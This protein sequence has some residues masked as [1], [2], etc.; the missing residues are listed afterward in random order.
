MKEKL[1]F[2]PHS[3]INLLT[4]RETIDRAEERTSEIIK[5]RDNS[6]FLLIKAP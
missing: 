1:L 6:I 2:L 4:S 3:R 5:L